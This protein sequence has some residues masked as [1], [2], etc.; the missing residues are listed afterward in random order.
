MQDSNAPNRPLPDEPADGRAGE[1]VPGPAQAGAQEI[2]PTGGGIHPF[3]KVA[4]YLV[5]YF[6]VGVAV[7]LVL[8]IVGGIAVS[9]G[10]VEPLDIDPAIM[11]MSVEEMLE[12]IEPYLFHLVILT[13]LYTIGYTWAF[14]RIVDKRKLRSLGLEFRQGWA[15]DFGKGAALAIVILA[16]IF[17]F[18][19]VTN[20]IRI[21]GFARPAP[22]GASV[23]TYLL[24]AFLAFLVVGVYEELMFRGYILQ[25]LNERAGRV[26]SILVSSVLFAVLHGANPGADAF[27][28]FNTT[29]IAVILCVL[30]FRTRSLWMPI[31]FHFAWNFFLGHVYSMPVSGMPVYGI[32]NVVEVDPD[33]RLTGGSYGPEAGLACTIALGAWAA[34]LIWR[35]SARRER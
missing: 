10:L 30:Y 29:I 25:R 20:S 4:L 35:R 8:A 21:D 32:L 15:A 12:A 1:A 13:G 23:A 19:V 34:W 27:G 18:S 24:G 31:G 22:E 28:V 14:V 9:S 26:V 2:R 6:V 33:S 16:A 7:S 17:A 3:L 5:G 11:A